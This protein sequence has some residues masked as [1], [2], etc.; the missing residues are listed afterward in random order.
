MSD[1]LYVCASKDYS[2]IWYNDRTDVMTLDLY[3]LILKVNNCA[4]TVPPGGIMTIPM[5]TTS[6]QSLKWGIDAHTIC[7]S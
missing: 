1:A 2:N 6:M 7:H 4:M 5:Y 3:T